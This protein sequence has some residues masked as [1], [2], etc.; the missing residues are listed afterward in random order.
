MLQDNNS[1]RNPIEGAKDEIVRPHSSWLD[2]KKYLK[3][4]LTDPWYA[5]LA[6]I[7]NTIYAATHDFFTDNNI[8]PFVFPI[9]TG[10]VSSP[11]GLGSDS[12]PVK[13]PLRD[14][15]VYLADSMQFS[16]E[17][18]ARLN[19]DGAY[20]IMP[21]FRGEEVDNRHLNEFV[22]AEVEITGNIEN[23][24]TLAESYVRYVVST[25]RDQ[26]AN[27][28]TSLVGN[29]SHIDAF[30]NRKGAFKQIEYKDA[31]EAVKHIEGALD[32]VG[33][34]HPVITS[35]GEKALLSQHGDFIWLTKM[36]WSNVPFY[37]A[38]DDEEGYSKT[39]DMLAGIGE[40]LGC[41]QRVYDQ[42]DLEESLNFH[43]VN[44]KGYEWYSEMRE[45]N[46]LQTAGFGL[47]IERL[48]LW[49]T[50]HDDIRD[51]SL[52]YRDHNKIFYP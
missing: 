52:L 20:Y 28:I 22:H 1:S 17:I 13:I 35:I 19:K 50:K 15:E 2:K 3:D 7:S 40:I 38:K 44:I 37:Q 36:P 14:N 49:L 6:Y 51:C 21:T 12:K 16:L 5:H 41:G 48:I 11:M 8:K 45:V 9:T 25:V 26:C 29:T 4:L 31:L 30:L 24:M 33:T 10:S 39:A 23:I 47:G 18:G 42:N 46:P 43:Q 32:S 27:S 34:D